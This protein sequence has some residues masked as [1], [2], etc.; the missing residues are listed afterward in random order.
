MRASNQQGMRVSG[1]AVHYYR[2][3][4]PGAVVTTIVAAAANTTGLWVCRARISANSGNTLALMVKAS[5]PS[6]ISDAA[7]DVL[8]ICMNNSNLEDRY[9][10]PTF[11][12]PGYGLYE[13]STAG[14]TAVSVSYK[15][16]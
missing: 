9:E 15:V 4:N 12:P 5:A 10:G 2:N 13:A 7:A 11:I 14:T 3:S 1:A 8:A 6:G 16:A